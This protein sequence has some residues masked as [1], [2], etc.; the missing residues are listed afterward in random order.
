LTVSLAV[1][2][3][4]NGTFLLMLVGLTTRWPAASA[5]SDRVAKLFATFTLLVRLV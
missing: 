4:P 1:V 2:C 5:K 3:S